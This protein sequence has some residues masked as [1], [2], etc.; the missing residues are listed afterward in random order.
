MTGL[1]DVF[2]FVSIEVAR[3]FPHR[4][5]ANNEAKAEKK[6]GEVEAISIAQQPKDATHAYLTAQQQGRMD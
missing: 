2:S 4:I 6:T 5:F 1:T 3:L